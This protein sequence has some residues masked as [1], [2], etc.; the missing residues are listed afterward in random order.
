MLDNKHGNKTKVQGLVGGSGLLRGQQVESLLH[1]NPLSGV[2]VLRGETSGVG[3]HGRR[4]L[5]IR[6]K[7]DHKNPGVY[8]VNSNHL[9]PQL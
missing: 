4:T 5:G 8:I 7:K 2:L 1:G 9:P 3:T 6:L